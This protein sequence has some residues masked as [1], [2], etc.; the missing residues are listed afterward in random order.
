MVFLKTS[1]YGDDSASLVPHLSIILT[2]RKQS[3]VGETPSI[4]KQ[5]LTKTHPMISFQCFTV[6]YQQTQ[7]YTYKTAR[8]IKKDNVL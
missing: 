4:K 1:Q 6:K 2:P 7:A 5:L 8:I 3:L